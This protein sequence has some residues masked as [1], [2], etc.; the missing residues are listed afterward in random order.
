[1]VGWTVYCTTGTAQ[2]EKGFYS[3]QNPQDGH[4]KILLKKQWGQVAGGLKKKGE[5]IIF[6]GGGEGGETTKYNLT[7]NFEFTINFG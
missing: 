5:F 7:F 3:K 2:K 1:M 4:S 6:E